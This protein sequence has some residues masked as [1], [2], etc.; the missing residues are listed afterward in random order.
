MPFCKEEILRLQIN[1]SS[2]DKMRYFL[3]KHIS[4]SVIYLIKAIELKQK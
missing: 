1:F 3:G 4:G 2:F